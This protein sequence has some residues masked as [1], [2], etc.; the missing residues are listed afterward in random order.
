L[1]RPQGAGGGAGFG[2]GKL[3][4]LYGLARWL[5]LRGSLSWTLGDWLG[6]RR[7]LAAVLGANLAIVLWRQLVRG[8]C[9]SSVYGRLHALTVPLRAPWGNLLNVCATVRALT[10]FAR[11][12]AL[13]RPLRWTKTAHDYPG[14]GLA[15]VPRR[16][17]QILV[18]MQAVSQVEV[19]QALRECPAGAYRGA[20][21]RAA[22][23]LGECLMRRGRV[24]EDQLHQ[25]LA[26]QAGLPFARL[27]PEA[28]D[29]LAC[30][31]LVPELC[32]SAAAPFAVN[33]DGTL[34]VAVRE[35]PS[36]QLRETLAR[37]CRLPLRFVMVTAS[38]F[39]KLRDW[40]QRLPAWVARQR[41]RERHGRRTRRVR[42]EAAR[43]ELRV[44]V[45][46]WLV[47]FRHLSIKLEYRRAR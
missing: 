33:Q 32:G 9:S 35:A 28:A 1:A 6:G 40:Q 22:E 19:E 38:N 3:L 23:R 4:F 21:G 27:E 11:A 47:A 41:E 39:E 16:L 12:R 15:G 31:Y 17:G 43:L 29:A 25:A 7:W 13:R 37:Q 24:T 18:S 20:D 45:P 8:L 2:A 30:R 34:C 44:A 10:A 26:L 5:L 36:R 42:L 14:S 46:A